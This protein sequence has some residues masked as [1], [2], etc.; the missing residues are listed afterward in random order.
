MQECQD[1]GK[2]LLDLISADTDK[3]VD[4][5][6]KKI[7]SI[8]CASELKTKKQGKIQRTPLAS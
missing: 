8:L 3:F 5:A 4:P 1:A 6:H 7:R 2:K